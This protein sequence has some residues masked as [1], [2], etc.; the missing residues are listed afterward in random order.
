MK[1]RRN[2]YGVRRPCLRCGRQIWSD[3][4]RRLCQPCREDNAQLGRAGIPV[5]LSAQAAA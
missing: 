2:Q 5:S 4:S 3:A 1:A